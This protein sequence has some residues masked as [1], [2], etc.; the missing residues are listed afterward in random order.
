MQL[1]GS[2]RFREFMDAAPDA[3]VVTGRDG[4]IV[5]TNLHTQAI[6]GYDA[7]ELT[8]QPIEILVPPRFRERHL[9]H[10]A[11]YAGNPH[12]RPMGAGL[13]LWG[14]RKDGIEFPVEISIS[15]LNS[16]N[17]PLVVAAIRDVTDRK[18]IEQTRDH[19][20]ASLSHE[21]RTPL[22]AILG[23]TGTLLMRLPGPLTSEQ[24]EQLATVQTSARHLLSLI[25]DLLDLAKLDSGKVELAFEDVVCQSVVNEVVSTLLPL[26]EAKGLRLDVEVPASDIVIRTN[27][28]AL[29]QIVINLTN[30][31]IKFT[32]KGGVGLELARAHRDGRP[33]VEIRVRDTGIGIRPEDQAR[34]FT[35]FEQIDA[36]RVDGTGLGLHL[37]RRLADLL[38]A[39]ISF[40]SEVG[41]GSTFTLALPG[42][43]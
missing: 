23:F 32:E 31:A 13:E 4:R 24:E 41:R 42:T 2:E 30:N 36:R 34:L 43:P 35:A 8:G 3:M 33:V 37:S 11:G 9:A 12:R 6:F 10:R 1:L 20:L 22:N 40:T 38:G 29:A 15:P 5:A 17:E 19:F 21:L 28:R 25:D 7:A 18:R 26:A 14:L 27:R 39:H 16:E